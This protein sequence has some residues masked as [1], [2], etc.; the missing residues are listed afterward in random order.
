LWSIKAQEAFEISKESLAKGTFL[1][2]PKMN[3]E[4]AL[5]TDIINQSIRTALQQ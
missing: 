1:V 2:H 5:F 3:A 4:L